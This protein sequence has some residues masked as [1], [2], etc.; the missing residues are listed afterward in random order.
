M[1]VS[2]LGE[3]CSVVICVTQIMNTHD[4]ATCCTL[5]SRVSN[6]FPGSIDTFTTGPLVRS[7]PR[8]RSQTAPAHWLPGL[9]NAMHRWTGQVRRAPIASFILEAGI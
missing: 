1:S 3:T 2:D 4:Q 8:F 7:V 9:A 5:R 6:N